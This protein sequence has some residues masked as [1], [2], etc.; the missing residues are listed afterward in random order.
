MGNAELFNKIKDKLG[1]QYKYNIEPI[2]S[3]LKDTNEIIEFKCVLQEGGE[4]L[5]GLYSTKLNK[6]IY[7]PVI[8]SDVI[9]HGHLDLISLFNWAENMNVWLDL[10]G[11]IILMDGEIIEAFRNN[12]Y[13]VNNLYYNHSASIGPVGYSIHELMQTEG[14]Y[15]V[16]DFSSRLL[17]TGIVETI[18]ESSGRYLMIKSESGHKLLIGVYDLDELKWACEPV[19]FH[20]PYRDK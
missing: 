9:Y 5:H 10:N 2:D 13:L 12:C 4:E 20:F 17:I 16:N 6:V 8:C 3:F 14:S 11:K 15:A 7:E 18:P 1:T 19:N